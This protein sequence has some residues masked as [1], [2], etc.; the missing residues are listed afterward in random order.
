MRSY[1]AALAVPD[2]LLAL[3]ELH[4]AQGRPADAAHAYKRLLAAASTSDTRSRPGP[5][6]PGPLL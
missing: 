5:L 6:G 2:A 3:G 4:E 1:P